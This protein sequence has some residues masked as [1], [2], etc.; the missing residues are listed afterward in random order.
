MYC[1]NCGA[2]M[3]DKCAFC[4]NCGTPT[5]QNNA[6]YCPNCGGEVDP[7]A[8]F[9]TACGTPLGAQQTQTRANP[10]AS[11]VKRREIVTAILLSIVTCGIY[12]IIWFVSLTNEIN[13]L[14]GRNNDTSG[15]MC[16][17]LTLVTCGIYGY[18]W[19]YKIGEKCD[20]L[21]GSDDSKILYLI[22]MFFCPIV[23]YALAQD[24]IN[25]T[26]GN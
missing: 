3:D 14:T 5:G 13:A 26:V 22:L 20:Q 11:W 23:T 19:G 17:L 25:K 12:S 24:T 1:K 6:T 15:G 7:N 10:A 21:K 16:F 4:P 18:Y 8:A 9:C 2:S